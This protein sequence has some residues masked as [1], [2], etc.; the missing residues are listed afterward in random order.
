M[1][2]IYLFQ[3]RTLGI[4][5]H[6]IDLLRNNYC[7][8]KIEYSDI[9]SIG[10]RKGLIRRWIILLTF[11]FTL[12]LFAFLMI[13]NVYKN[14]SQTDFWTNLLLFWRGAR[15]S[16]FVA[17]IFLLVFGI[18]SIKISLSKK[19]LI[20]IETRNKKRQYEISQIA[21]DKK[22]NALITFLKTRV[23]SLVVDESFNVI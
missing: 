11:G 13:L 10:F 7:Y 17:M 20:T 16:G 15:G 9:R 6:G 5:E 23:N 8:D 21:K 12:I 3:D 18:Y 19:I 14:S 1:N 4:Y 22:L 2:N